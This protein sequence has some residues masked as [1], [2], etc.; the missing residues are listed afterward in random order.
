MSFEYKNLLLELLKG[1]EENYLLYQHKILK[2]LFTK[3]RCGRPHDPPA[4]PRIFKSRHLC[5]SGS[6]KQCWDSAV[7]KHQEVRDELDSKTLVL[8]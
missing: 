1:E 3:Q 8:A 6:C 4:C 5:N 7:K 2:G